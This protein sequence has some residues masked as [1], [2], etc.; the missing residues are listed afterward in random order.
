MKNDSKLIIENVQKK[1]WEYLLGAICYLFISD[2][3]IAS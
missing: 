2:A 1:V 3:R